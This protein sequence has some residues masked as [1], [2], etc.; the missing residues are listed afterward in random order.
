MQIGGNYNSNYDSYSNPNYNY[1]THTHHFTECLHEEQVMKKPEGGAPASAGAALEIQGN[2]TAGKAENIVPETQ[3]GGSSFGKKVLGFVQ[4]IWDAMGKEG[5]HQ[6]NPVTIYER[7]DAA[8]GKGL[9]R[10]VSVAS[11]AIKQ[12]FSVQ[13]VGRLETVRE[14]IKVGVHTAL[15]RFGKDSEPFG[16]LTDPGTGS[17]LGGRAGSGARRRGN[18]SG[19]R[20]DRNQV[21][22]TVQMSDEHLMDS[23]S[24]SGTYCKINENLTYQQGRAPYK[25][26]DRAD[27]PK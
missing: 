24:K 19:T 13:V 26:S 10:S 20:Q 12:S 27:L 4:G 1:T 22:R 9:L 2:S 18:K 17:L 15:K 8:S 14:K 6:Q 16:T 21:I 5:S 3:T 25:V 7:E 11:S 23:Y